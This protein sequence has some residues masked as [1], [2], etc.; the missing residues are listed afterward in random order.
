MTLEPIAPA[1]AMRAMRDALPLRTERLLLRT[2]RPDDL[3]AVRAYRNAPGQ[4]RWV[5][6][7]PRQPSSSALQSRA[8]SFWGR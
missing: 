8:D 7:P 4:R 6:Q 5:R 3:D 1:D 2:L